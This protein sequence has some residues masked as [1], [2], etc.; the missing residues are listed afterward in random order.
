MRI[1]ETRYARSG[2]VSIVSWT[3]GERP[4]DLVLTPG[5]GSNAEYG[6]QIPILASWRRLAEFSRLISFDKRGTALSEDLGVG[7]GIAFSDRG[8]AEPKGIRGER[9]LF[10]VE[11]DGSRD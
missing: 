2:D 11:G 7:S 5:S 9:H 1:P 8:S 10:A 6:W 3:L 4:L